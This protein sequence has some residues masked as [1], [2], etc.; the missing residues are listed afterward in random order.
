MMISSL[1]PLLFGA[2]L[3]LDGVVGGDLCARASLD[4]NNVRLGDPLTLAIDFT[5]T[6]DLEN[7]HP[8]AISRAVESALWKVGDKSATTDTSR[9]GS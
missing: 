9:G 3:A 5:G 6:A 4:S 1:F 7:I 8:P 2:A